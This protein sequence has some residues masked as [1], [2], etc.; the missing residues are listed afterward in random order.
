MTAVAPIAERATRYP[1]LTVSG[2]P[3]AMGEQI[4]EALREYI[5]GFDAIALDRV[6]KTMDVSTERTLDVARRCSQDA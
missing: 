4:G 1:E 3:T 2:S 5:R 6:R